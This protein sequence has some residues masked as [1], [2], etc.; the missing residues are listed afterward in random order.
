MDM[1]GGKWLSEKIDFVVKDK[2]NVIKKGKKKESP[3]VQ[4]QATSP[5]L[6]KRLKGDKL[7]RTLPSLV[8]H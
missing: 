7:R 2:I 1:G 8:S 3:M 6:E 5:R 4:Y